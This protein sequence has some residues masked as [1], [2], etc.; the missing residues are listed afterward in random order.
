MNLR[1]TRQENQFGTTQAI[2]CVPDPRLHHYIEG[3][4]LGWTENVLRPVTMRETP[5]PIIPMIFNLGP[6]WRLSEAGRDP[7]HADSFLSG[8][9]EHYTLVES[10]G[11]SSCMQV[12]FT[13]LGALRLLGVP[14][15]EIADRVIAID[16]LLGVAGR[17]LI[18]RLHNA[19]HWPQRF[20][21]LERFFLARFAEDRATS[22]EAVWVWDNLR[23]YDGLMPIAALSAD[24]GWSH[25]RLIAV[26]HH[27]FGL[28][29]K[30][31]ARV[32][33]FARVVR[34]LDGVPTPRWAE[35]A[36]DCGYYDQAHLHRDFRQFAGVTPAGYFAGRP[37]NYGVPGY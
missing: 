23:R 13:P 30:R 21:E 9:S 4:Y 32:M 3:N 24:L 14:L 1:L 33:R 2:F 34:S 22:R 25:K 19:S 11:R 10:T 35:I 7:Y 16:E 12:N 17:D 15:L 6:A 27:E 26:F 28:T 8:L 18:A 29:P 36:A 31:A 37:P 20:L 5:R